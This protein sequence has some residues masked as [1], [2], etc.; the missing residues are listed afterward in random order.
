MQ[1]NV[2]VHRLEHLSMKKFTINLSQL[3]QNWPKS[4]KLVMVLKKALDKVGFIRSNE[5]YNDVTFT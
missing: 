3:L 1:A 2:V 5:H 4:V